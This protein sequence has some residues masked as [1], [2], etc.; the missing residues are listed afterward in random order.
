MSR[1]IQWSNSQALAILVIG[2]FIGLLVAGEY[3]LS[4]I[5]IFVFRLSILFFCFFVLNLYWQIV[6]A[7]NSKSKSMKVGLV[8]I[9]GI[10]LTVAMLLFCIIFLIDI[11]L[12]ML[13]R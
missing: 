3:A 5:F 11:A 13:C 1:N 6:E 12:E 10:G 9:A 4:S 7:D 2:I 8:K